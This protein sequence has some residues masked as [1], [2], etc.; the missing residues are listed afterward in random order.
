MKRIC[1][2]ALA[3]C[4]LLSLPG[5]LAN[6]EN[7]KAP[8]NF[9][10]LRSDLTYWESDSVIAAE[11]REAYGHT[12][13]LRYLILLY[14]RGPASSGLYSPFPAETTLAGLKQNGSTLTITLDGCSLT[15]QSKLQATLACV[16]LAKTC[17]EL[18]DITSVRV[19]TLS[20]IASGEADIIVDAE[21]LLLWDECAT[22]PPK[23]TEDQ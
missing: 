9:Y 8:V 23:T 11:V 14:L 16:S 6:E 19:N 17:F 22:V 18:A 5:C 4:L 1:A 2:L 10:Y 15:E 13:D 21:T 20:G 7:L 12:E 3:V